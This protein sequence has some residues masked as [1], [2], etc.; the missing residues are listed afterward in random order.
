MIEISVCHFGVSSAQ[1][2]CQLG[3]EAIILLLHC[4]I[5]T[6]NYIGKPVTID[7]TNSEKNKLIPTWENRIQLLVQNNQLKFNLFNFYSNPVKVLQSN[8]KAEL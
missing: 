3:S 5:I 7:N 1:W 4:V 2:V 6:G 8:W